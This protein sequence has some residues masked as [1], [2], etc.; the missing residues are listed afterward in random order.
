LKF[1]LKRLLRHVIPSDVQYPT[2]VQFN[3]SY[4]VNPPPG[5]VKSSM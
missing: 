4:Y 3:P 5:F 2:D 1:L